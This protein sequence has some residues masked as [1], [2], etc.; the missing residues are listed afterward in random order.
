MISTAGFDFSTRED[1]LITVL[2]SEIS[3][4][5]AFP[6]LLL[7]KIRRRIQYPDRSRSFHVQPGHLV[8]YWSVP[9]GGPSTH[10]FE[11]GLPMA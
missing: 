4:S 3:S 7:M 1:P 8:R 9:H 6:T 5:F 11:S 10:R 2:A